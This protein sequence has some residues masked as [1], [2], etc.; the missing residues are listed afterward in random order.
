MKEGQLTKFDSIKIGDRAELQHTITQD[1]IDKFVEL[2]GDDNKLHVDLDYAEKTIFKKPVA[3]GMLGASF[4]STIIGTKLPGDGALWYAQ[5]LEFLLPVRIGDKLTVIAEVKNKISKTNSIELATDIF[6]QNNQ[7]V[8]TGVAKVKLIESKNDEPNSAEKDRS[9]KVALIIG[10]TGG[11]GQETCYTLANDGYEIAIHYNKNKKRAEDIR[12]K[13]MGQGHGRNTI[14]VQSDITDLS[15]VDEMVK[16]VLRKLTTIT[17]VVNCSTIRVPNIKFESVDWESFQRHFELNIKGT[18][19]ILKSV[20]PIMKD[21]KYGKI[22]GISTQYVEAPKPE[23]SHYITAKSGLIGFIKSLSLELAPKGI[24]M[25]LVSPGMTDTALISDVPEKVRILT[26]TQTPLRRL[27]TAGDV[28]GA[29]SF[30]AS[31][32]S[33]YLSGETIRVNGGQIML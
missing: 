25:N 32:K 27:A 21:E 9:K 4:I 19:N 24:R 2:T 13:I 16:K 14:I 10:G 12:N 5:N 28:A 33:D 3:H 30:L 8:T 17:T 20:V 26:A 23:L 7:K 15:S 11:I 22:I 1:D 29:I 18:F 31:D 6:N